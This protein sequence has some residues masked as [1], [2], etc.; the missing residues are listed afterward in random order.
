MHRDNIDKT[1]YPILW[2]RIHSTAYYVDSGKADKSLFISMFEDLLD[3]KGLGCESCRDDTVRYIN[4]HPISDASDDKY[5]YLRWTW[6]FHNHVNSKIGK[7]MYDWNKCLSVYNEDM[8]SEDKAPSSCNS[9][10]IA[11]RSRDIPVNYGNLKGV[12]RPSHL[13]KFYPALPNV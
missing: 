11:S 9:C 2:D 1:M 8:Y 7:S 5:K 12:P 4:S 13:I 3:R 6:Q 10:K